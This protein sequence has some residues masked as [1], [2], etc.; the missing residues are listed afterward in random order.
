MNAFSRAG[1]RRVSAASPRAYSASVCGLLVVMNCREGGGGG[2]CT[3]E[4]TQVEPGEER[5]A[6]TRQVYVGGMGTACLA[7]WAPA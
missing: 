7:S 2:R 5:E 4:S 1:E 6:T 3:G